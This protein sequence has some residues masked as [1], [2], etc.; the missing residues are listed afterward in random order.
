LVAKDT[1]IERFKNQLLQLETN[2]KNLKEEDYSH[3][4]PVSCGGDNCEAPL[5]RKPHRTVLRPEC[6]TLGSPAL[7]RGIALPG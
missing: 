4:L 5:P 7:L 6:F 2:V 1:E 3:A